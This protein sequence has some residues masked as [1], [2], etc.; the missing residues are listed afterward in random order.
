MVLGIVP[1]D[2]DS[3]TKAFIDMKT[4]LDKEKTA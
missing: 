2:L 1:N 4:E 3:L